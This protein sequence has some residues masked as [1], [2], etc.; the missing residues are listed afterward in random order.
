[1]KKVV[2]LL[3][4]PFTADPRV[5]REAQTLVQH[6]FQV[7]VLA[8]DRK[9]NH[10]PRD[11]VQ[12]IQVERLSVRGKYG[13]GGASA[14]SFATFNVGIVTRLL[15]MPFDVV[16]CHDLDTTLAG[17]VGARLRRKPLIFDAHEA[18]S[19]YERFSPLLH[20]GITA[21][22]RFVARR[23]D[24]VVTVN[25]LM[26]DWFSELGSQRVVVVPNYPELD[27]LQKLWGPSSPGH[28]DEQGDGRGRLVIG[29]LG[30]IKPSSNVGLIIQAMRQAMARHPSKELQLLLVGSILPS[31]RSE[32]EAQAHS[33]ADHVTIVGPVPYEE[34]PAYYRQIDVTVIV[35]AVTGNNRLGSALKLYES[36]AAGVPVIVSLLGEPPEVVWRENCGLVLDDYQVSTLANALDLLVSQPETRVEMGRNGLRAVRERYRWDVVAQGLLDVYVRCCGGANV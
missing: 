28:S 30:S 13:G 15:R 1:M 27:F 16:H 35:D 24:W 29:R 4:N 26:G 6:G 9:G 32:L 22:E 36:M 5:L 33:M 3:S 12:G 25:R 10:P 20:R 14:L 34:V 11:E 17:F 21:L 2:M 7:T 18:Y 8:W 31:Y 23:A 19:Q